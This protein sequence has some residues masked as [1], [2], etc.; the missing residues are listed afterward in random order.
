MAYI[1]SVWRRL[2]RILGYRDPRRWPDICRCTFWIEIVWRCNFCR[3]QLRPISP[4][5]YARNRT[6]SYRLHHRNSLLSLS[7]RRAPLLPFA[8]PRLFFCFFNL[9]FANGSPT[10]FCSSSMLLI[11]LFS[12]FV[13]SNIIFHLFWLSFSALVVVWIVLDRRRN[14]LN[15][16]ICALMSAFTLF[17]VYLFPLHGAN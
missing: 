17:V 10:F 1:P 11:Q 15:V 5:E 12:G 9:I 13:Y 7:Y 8:A 2:N 4:A 3:R 14:N 16:L 6:F